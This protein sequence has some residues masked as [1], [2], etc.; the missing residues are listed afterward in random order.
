MRK[1]QRSK[2]FSDFF[3]LF[4]KGGAYNWNR[5]SDSKQNTFSIYWFLTKLQNVIVEAQGRAYHLE[6]HFFLFTGGLPRRRFQGRDEKRAPL[7]TPAWEAS[8]PV[9]WLI[10]EGAYKLGDGGGLKAVVYGSL[11]QTFRYWGMH[12]EKKN[13]PAFF[14]ALFLT[15]LRPTTGYHK[16]YSC[17]FLSRT[18][19]CRVMYTLYRSD[20]MLQK[21]PLRRLL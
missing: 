10:T 8:L 20:C 3:F 14:N 19:K 13:Y 17:M 1:P 6:G 12:K 7:K 18:V 11:F 15:I 5:E 16:L 2:E 4:K 21:T 9:D